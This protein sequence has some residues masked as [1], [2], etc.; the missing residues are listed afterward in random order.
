M[1]IVCSRLNVE[2]KSSRRVAGLKCGGR[3]C[4]HDATRDA[5]VAKDFLDGAQLIWEK[6]AP[7]GPYGYGASLEHQNGARAIFWLTMYAEEAG[8]R[9]IVGLARWGPI[10]G[11]VGWRPQV[12]QGRKGGWDT[13]VNCKIRAILMVSETYLLE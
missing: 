10:S 6:R 8:K 5:G 13:Q 7:G 2:A 3:Y 9:G 4:S 12:F 1:Q 11:L